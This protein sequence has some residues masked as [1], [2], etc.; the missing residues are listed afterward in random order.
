MDGN[1]G[2]VAVP[3]RHL[4]TSMDLV[5]CT[6]QHFIKLVTSN[7]LTSKQNHAASAPS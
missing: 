1:D 6:L 7:L 4:P 5:Q 2:E 3:G